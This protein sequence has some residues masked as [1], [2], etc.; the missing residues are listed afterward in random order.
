MLVHGQAQ[1][2]EPLQRLEVRTEGGTALDPPEL[3]APERQAPLGRHPGVL[4][5]QRARGRVAGV[6]VGLLAPL[7]L[8]GVEPFEG[9]EAQ[10]DLAAHLEHRGGRPAQTD[11]DVGDGAHRVGD[12]LAGPAVA[13][14]GGPHQHPVVVANRYGE[15]VKLELDRVGLNR[16]VLQRRQSLLA[17]RPDGARQPTVHPLVPGPQL[18]DVEGVVQRHHR[19][20]VAHRREGGVGRGPDPL[21]G[22]IGMNQLRMLRLQSLQLPEHVVEV[23]VGDLG[24]VRV[25]EGRMVV[26]Q[27]LQLA[28]ERP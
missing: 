4:L 17:R 9:G 12:V 22:R 11:G 24:L 23:T 16:G 1:R 2:L 5:A 6:D 8:A 25:V 10:E 7:G 13:P 27:G 19:R 28:H 20:L 18:V 21:G 26:E 14:R 15:P 3:V